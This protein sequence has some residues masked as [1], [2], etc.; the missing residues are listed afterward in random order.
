MKHGKLGLRLLAVVCVLSLLLA[1]I[2]SA[3]AASY[4]YD[5]V[6]MDDVNLRSRANTTSTVVKKIQAG[7]AVTILG[8]TGDFY[9][10]KFDGKTGY[11]MKKFIDG[12]DSSPDAPRMTIIP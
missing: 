5:T 9:R 12:T 3:L 7:D 10:V 2:P 11:A 1:M 8:A 4:P 6:S